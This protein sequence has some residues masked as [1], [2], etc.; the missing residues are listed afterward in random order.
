VSRT[1]RML[2]IYLNVDD[3]SSSKQDLENSKISER[4]SLYKRLVETGDNLHTRRLDYE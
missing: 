3:D 2:L 4:S 1:K